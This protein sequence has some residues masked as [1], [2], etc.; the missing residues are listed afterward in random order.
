MNFCEGCVA[1]AEGQSVVCI[2]GVILTWRQLAL[3]ERIE[4][5]QL[6]SLHVRCH[7]SD[8]AWL[9]NLNRTMDLRFL[10]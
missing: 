2:T 1:G 5:R 4:G 9:P 10:G 6:I 7:V 8:I 3:V